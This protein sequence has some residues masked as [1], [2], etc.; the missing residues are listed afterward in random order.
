MKLKIEELYSSE[1]GKFV[2]FGIK[3]I[4]KMNILL[5]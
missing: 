5:S 2:I 3:I 1:N 4:I